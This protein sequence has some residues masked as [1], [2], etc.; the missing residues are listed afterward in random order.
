[1]ISELALKFD[2]TLERVA[3]LDAEGDLTND[4]ISRS[5]LSKDTEFVIAALAQRVG[6]S[7][8][9]INQIIDTRNGRFITAICWRA[10][11]SMRTALDIQ[12][13]IA[14]VPPKRMLYA[15][16]GEDFPM[17]PDEMFQIREMFRP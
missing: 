7:A 3:K 12:Q 6:V 9:V 1:M 11:L 5:A 13:R 8:D 10:K 4:L 14:G 2:S 17:E 15:K 16:R